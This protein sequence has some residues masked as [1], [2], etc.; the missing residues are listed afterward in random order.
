MQRSPSSTVPLGSVLAS[1]CISSAGSGRSQRE[2]R[3]LPR[4]GYRENP[5][6]YDSGASVLAVVL[7]L[8]VKRVVPE[9]RNV[10]PSAFRDCRAQCFGSVLGRGGGSIVRAN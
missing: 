6:G 2:K 10:E 8:L 7:D 1:V 5:A 9:E 4:F 3:G